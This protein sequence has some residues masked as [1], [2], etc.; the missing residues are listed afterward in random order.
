MV[1]VH[2]GKIGDF[3]LANGFAFGIDRVGDLFR[4]RAAI[5]DV[6]L[7]AKIPLRAA[8]IVAGRQHHAAESL[9]FTYDV[10]GRWGR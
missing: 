4:C 2:I 9:V 5:A 8:L 6:V 10:R 7:D 1:D 3:I